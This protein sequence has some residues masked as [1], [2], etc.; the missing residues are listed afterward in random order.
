MRFSSRL[1]LV[2]LAMMALLSGLIVHSS[3][4]VFQTKPRSNSRSE[5]FALLFKAVDKALTAPAFQTE[6][7][8]EIK[9]FQKIKDSQDSVVNIQC[10][11][12]IQF[13]TQAIVQYP[14]RFRLE[15][16]VGTET[17]PRSTIV[18]DGQTVSIYRSDLKQFTTMSYAEFDQR[19]GT[20]VVSLSSALYMRFAPMLKKS[21]GVDSLAISILPDTKMTTEQTNNGNL[22]VYTHT[23]QQ[24]DTAALAVNPIDALIKQ[25]RTSGSSDG[26]FGR[27]DSAMTETIQRQ[28]INPTIPANTFQ[29][30]PP[31]DAERVNSISLSPPYNSGDI[32]CDFS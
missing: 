16:R 4:A 14:N 20:F 12:T 7:L 29:F 32:A 23:N 21:G 8:T 25:V 6:S 11:V 9:G 5:D 3:P 31:K 18:S 15:V 17:T 26:S 19:S 24:G 2:S 13:R 27:F 10:R 1:G 28:T 30:T 22:V